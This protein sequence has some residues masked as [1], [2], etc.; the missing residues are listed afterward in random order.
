MH[1]WT[2]GDLDRVRGIGKACAK[3]WTGQWTVDYGLWTI[4]TA[5]YGLW[6]VDYGL[7]TA[8]GL[9]VDCVLVLS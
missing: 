5:D 9:Y 7:W 1:A 6:T 8:C 4:W 3:T 2:Y